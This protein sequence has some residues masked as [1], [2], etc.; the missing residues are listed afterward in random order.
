[1]KK[2]HAAGFPHAATGKTDEWFTPQKYIDAL[3]GYRSFDLDPCSI[4]EPPTQTA[5][6]SFRA[7]YGLEQVWH[8]RVWLNPPYNRR[9]IGDW[10]EKMA[11]HNHGTALVSA[12]TETQWFQRWVFGKATALCFL[13]GRVFF[14][15]GDGMRGKHGAGGSSVLVA[16]G[17]DDAQILQTCGLAGKFVEL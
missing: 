16:Y 8:G 13:E 10:M 7:P 17:E 15:D 1:M 5:Q 12:R 11:D 6:V 3:G 9:V 4:Q 14:L 2:M